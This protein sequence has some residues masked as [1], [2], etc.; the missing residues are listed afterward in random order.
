MPKPD[1]RY[2]RYPSPASEPINHD[3]AHIDYKTAFR[4]SIHMIRYT[5]E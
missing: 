3:D 4:D 2:P 5:E 1:I